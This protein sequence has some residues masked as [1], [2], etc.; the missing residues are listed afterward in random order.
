MN[1][2]ML[3]IRESNI[4]N[5]IKLRMRLFLQQEYH[6]GLCRY[7]LKDRKDFCL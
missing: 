4:L 3:L 2:I 7:V 5:S 1:K 6:P